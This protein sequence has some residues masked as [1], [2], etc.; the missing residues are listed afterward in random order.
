MMGLVAEVLT[1][2]NVAGLVVRVGDTVR[3]PATS[4]T[5][6]VTADYWG[7]AADYIERHVDV[8]RAGLTKE[9]G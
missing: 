9:S 7:P 5:P 1:G 4:A 3:K 6:A 8:W 2:G